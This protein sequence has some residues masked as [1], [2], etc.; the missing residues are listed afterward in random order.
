MDPISAA[1]IGISIVS[2]VL[3]VFAGCVKGMYLCSN[4]ELWTNLSG[5]E[6]YLHASGVP[7]S[8]QHLRTRL[9]IEQARLLNWGESVGLV[10]ELLKS[11]S[12]VL[13]LN[14]NLILDILLEIQA[15]FKSCVE[16]GET[17]DRFVPDELP[18]SGTKLGQKPASFLKR[19]LAILDKKPKIVS[20]LQWAMIKQNQFEALIVKLIAFN[21]RIES[22]LDR[23]SLEKL[24]F[25]HQ[26]THM[27]MLQLTEQ[28]VELRT[29]SQAILIKG[30]KASKLPEER[31]SRSSTLVAD[32]ESEQGIFAGL[33][34]FKAQQ[35]A[36]DYQSGNLLLPYNKFRWSTDGDPALNSR[37]FGSFRD[38]A[39]F[40]EWRESIED[41][42][43]R[44]QL[45]TVVEERVRKLAALLKSPKKPP[46]F[47]APSCIGY[48]WDESYDL[49]RYGLVYDLDATFSALNMKNDKSQPLDRL[50]MGPK[51]LRVLLETLTFPSLNRRIML[52]QSLA[53]ALM[54]LHSVNWLHKGFR[55][56]SILFAVPTKLPDGKTA[57]LDAPVVSGFDFSRPD[58]PEEVTLQNPNKIEY[59]LYRHPDL[60]ILDSKTRAQKSH[61]IFSL[62]IVL[63]EIAHWKP[64]E[65]ILGIELGSKSTRSNVIKVRDRLVNEM[66]LKA[67]VEGFAGEVYANVTWRCIEGGWIEKGEIETSPMVGAKMQNVFF[68]D[69]W[70]RLGD[71]QV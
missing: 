64:I 55:S 56:E 19:S 34:A 9:R 68:D 7:E 53:S 71:I 4:Q 36:P 45:D 66:H 5:Y 18:A 70:R 48:V 8:Y 51:S 20:R 60:Q 65:K 46:E 52:A 63:L 33:A 54:Y 15:A 14:H 37:R 42:R 41:P 24:Q 30:S 17:F 31:L 61:D 39:V 13:Q 44:S 6:I 28:V 38:R 35:N 27:V 10:E 29:L 47:R 32:S 26:Q 16:I 59:D 57:N 50:V 69:V 2:L 21:D 11:P 22:L 25:M 3:Q 1:G 67:A 40:V 49:P 23:S 62:G 43:P 58:L 12:H